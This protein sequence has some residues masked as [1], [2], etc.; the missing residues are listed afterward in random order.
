MNY[1]LFLLALPFF[2]AVCILTFNILFEKK[3]SDVAG[4][5]LFRTLI[6][7]FFF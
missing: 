6:L 1:R 2:N 7:L 5:L 3:C 4:K